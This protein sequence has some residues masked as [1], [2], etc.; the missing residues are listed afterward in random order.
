MFILLFA[1]TFVTILTALSFCGVSGALSSG[2]LDAWFV[3]EH[4]R[5]HPDSNLQRSLAVIEVSGLQARASAQFSEVFCLRPSDHSLHDCFRS[6]STR[7][8]SWF[9]LRWRSSALSIL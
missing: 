3:D 2:S 6:A 4:Y 8:T 5:Q 9:P 7:Q 1:D